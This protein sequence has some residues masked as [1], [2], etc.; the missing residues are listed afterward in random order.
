M[1]PRGALAQGSFGSGRRSRTR[2]AIGAVRHVFLDADH[3]GLAVLSRLEAR[4]DLP[5]PSYVLH[6]S[7]NQIHVFWRVTRFDIDLV[8]RLRKQLARELQT[9]RAAT[10]VTQNT[11]LPGFF[12]YK[13]ALPHLVTVEYRNVD[14][15]HG[16]EN[17]PPVTRAVAWSQSVRPHEPPNVDVPAV[18]RAKRYL[19]SVPPAIA[20]NTVTSTR[21]ASAV[22][23]YEGSR[24]KWTRRYS[25]CRSG[26]RDA[27][28]PGHLRSCSTSFIVPRGT[29][30][31]R[32]GDC[33]DPKGR[34]RR[35][36]DP[37]PLPVGSL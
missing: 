25:C 34:F 5:T 22:G 17:F 9:D 37:G 3:D 14:V 18:E 12:N 32:L 27:C 19:T 28:R 15:T 20:A 24:W 6:S 35:S 26:T 21:S 11:R 30:A 2:D 33:C 31:N 1:E 16:P 23:S 4:R 7:P 36:S 29:D 13:R 8:E 10:P